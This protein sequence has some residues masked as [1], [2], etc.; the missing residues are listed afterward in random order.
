[1]KNCLCR[2]NYTEECFFSADY[3]FDPKYRKLC[4][5]LTHSAGCYSGSNLSTALMF[6]KIY[7]CSKEQ[8][9]DNIK[10][11]IDNFAFYIINMYPELSY[12]SIYKMAFERASISK[13][14]ERH[15]DDLP[16]EKQSSIRI[17]VNMNSI[18]GFIFQVAKKFAEKL[19]KDKALN[20]LLDCMVY[21]ALAIIAKEEIEISN[22]KNN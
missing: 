7:L 1:M 22:R 19:P 20:E 9:V 8:N 14:K 16:I 3:I 6:E 18:N 15:G 5:I 17:A 13:G 12:P 10:S 2:S 4:D 11:L 21:L